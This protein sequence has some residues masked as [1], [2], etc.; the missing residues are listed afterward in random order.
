MFYMASRGQNNLFL[1]NTLV[2]VSYSLISR[3]FYEAIE[4]NI[5]K[6]IIAIGSLSFMIVFAYDIHLVG[7]YQVVKISGTLQCFLLIAYCLIFFA[8][9]SMTLKVP[10]LLEWPVF[11]IAAG[12]FCYYS[13]TTF[14]TPIFNMVE[15]FGPKHEL[16]DVVIVSYAMESIYL[17]GV[18][19]GILVEK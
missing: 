18:G 2:L 13:A 8:W 11:W 1:Y 6:R 5:A 7:M 10:N 17:T 15:R 12:V 9:L 19:I 4:H 3:M 16:Y 14:T